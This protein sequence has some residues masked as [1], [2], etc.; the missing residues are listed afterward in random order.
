MRHESEI[1][2]VWEFA[3]LDLH[4]NPPPKIAS[5]KG[6]E[7]ESF[8]SGQPIER[9]LPVVDFVV[10]PRLPLPD[11][12]MNIPGFPL[13]SPKLRQA[14]TEIDIDNIQFFDTRLITKTAKVLR[15][16][17]QIGNVVGTVSCFDWERSEYDDSYRAQGAV[18]H[19]DKLVLDPERIQ[20]Q[21][22]FRM[23]EAR[24]ILLVAGSVRGHLQSR[25]ITGIQFVDLAGFRI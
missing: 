8:Q 19:I 4:G 18:I 25:G 6:I 24:N 10:S 3:A 2:S 22:L 12:L 7:E 1:Y 23:E 16:D 15:E 21:R 11:Y 14:L 17:F 13:F 5:L 20:G 9:R